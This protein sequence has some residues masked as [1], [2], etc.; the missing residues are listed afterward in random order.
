VVGDE[1]IIGKPV[2]SDQRNHKATYPALF[3]L[4]AAKS[5]QSL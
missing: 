5:A 1:Q 2:G 3:G 4:E